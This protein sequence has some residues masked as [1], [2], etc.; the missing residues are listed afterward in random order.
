[1]VSGLLMKSHCTIE[2]DMSKNIKMQLSSIVR[3]SIVHWAWTA[4]IILI[5]KD[6]REIKDTFA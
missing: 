5:I 1:M 2:T 6:L 3:M 4:W